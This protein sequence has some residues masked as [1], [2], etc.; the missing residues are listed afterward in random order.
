MLE[1]LWR[2][3]LTWADGVVG[4]THLVSAVTAIVSGAFVL[5]MRKGTRRHIV[6]GYVYVF[7]MVVLNVT[8]LVNYELTGGVN[9]FHISAIGSSLTLLAAFATA[10]V[11]RFTKSIVAAAAHG[12]FMIWSYYGL[13]LALV[14]EVGTRAFP[15]MLH[16]DGG[17]SRFLFG[18]MIA[19]ILSFWFVQRYAQYETTKTLGDWRTRSREPVIKGAR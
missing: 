13:L 2:Y 18:T 17:W 16:G 9:F 5:F 14:G 8:A 1:Y 4:E 19:V 10:M 15:S 11:Y 7:A 3:L 6:V 12:S